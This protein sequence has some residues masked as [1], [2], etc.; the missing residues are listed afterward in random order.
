MTQAQVGNLLFL[1][2]FSYMHMFKSTHLVSDIY[3]MQLDTPSYNPHYWQFVVAV[4]R[5]QAVEVVPVVVVVGNMVGVVADNTAAD[6][7]ADIPEVVAGSTAVD[8]EAAVLHIE[9][10]YTCSGHS[11]SHN[12]VRPYS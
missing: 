12:I 6:I 2:L 7:P 8:T 4:G 5:I 11:Y 1:W 9:A 10:W 3:T